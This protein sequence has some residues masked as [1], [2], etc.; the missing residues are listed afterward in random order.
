MKT[1]KEALCEEGLMT[2]SEAAKFLRLSRS[3]LYLLMKRGELIY[4]SLGRSRRV[5]RRAVVAFAARHLRT[6]GAGG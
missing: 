2:V 6:E 4:A 1:P 3:N 5:P